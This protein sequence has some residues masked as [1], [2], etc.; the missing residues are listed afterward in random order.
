MS[1]NPTY[2]LQNFWDTCQHKPK[3]KYPDHFD[4]E[5]LIFES[6]YPWFRLSAL[7][8]SPY[9]KML[10]E[11]KKID[12]LFVNHRDGDERYGYAHS[13]WKSVVLHGLG[14]DKTDTYKAYGLSKSQAKS[15]YHWTGA[16]KQCPTIVSWLQNCYPAEYFNR[17]RIMKLEPGGYIMPHVDM[18]EPR[19]TVC[20][21][22][23]NAPYQCEMVMKNHGKVPY[24]TNGSAFLVDISNEHAVWNQSDQARYIIIVHSEVGQKLREHFYICRE[25]FYI[26]KNQDLSNA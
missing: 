19:L 7:D 11:A 23:L 25:S 22:S 13:G 20:N 15:Q 8:N 10:E 16:A 18:N 21:I 9:Q 14:V 24:D 5:W 26:N 17:V 2:I 12:S 3:F 4:H 6:G 1:H